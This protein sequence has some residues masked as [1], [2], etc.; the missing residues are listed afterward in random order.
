MTNLE[1]KFCGTFVGVAVGDAL[2]GPAEE[3]PKYLNANPKHITEM[4]G[5]GWLKLKPGQITDDTEMTLCIARS[6]AEKEK[7]DP[8]NIAKKFLEWIED[9][10]LGTGSTTRAALAKFKKGFSWYEAGFTKK[11]LTLTGNGSVMRCSPIALLDYTDINKL[12]AHAVAQS[13]ITHP[14]AVCSDSAVFINAII[15]G[16]LNGKT[17][18]ESYKFAVDLIKY[19]ELLYNLYSKIHNLVPSKPF[20]EVRQTVEASVHCF[21]T[22]NS[23]E[24]AVVKAVNMGGDADTTGAVVGAIAGSYY[25]EKEIPLRWKEKLVDRN[26]KEIYKELC[27]LSG[28]IYVISKNQNI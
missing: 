3:V 7:F 5:G 11:G 18:E 20:G 28:K 1:D 15:A 25:G 14:Q 22:T 21:L 19:N 27:E 24:E 17:K 12:V 8:E 10:A 26:G 23:F 9:N 16:N 4:I 13:L 6:I 2:G